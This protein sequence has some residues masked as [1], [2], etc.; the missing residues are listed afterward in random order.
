[1]E[2]GR[3]ER[4]IPFMVKWTHI[5]FGKEGKSVQVSKKETP[6]TK[7]FSDEKDHNNIRRMG[8]HHE[9]S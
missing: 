6:L 8:P 7:S 5:V 1:M 2:V 9:G 3:H 4:G